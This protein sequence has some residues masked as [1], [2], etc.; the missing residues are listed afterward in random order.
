MEVDPLGDSALLLR[1]PK[2]VTIDKL[3]EMER[4]LAVA[5]LP[6]VIELAP[7]YETLAVFYDPVAVTTDEDASAFEI[8]SRKIVE[9]LN[10]PGSAPSARR[11]KLVEIPVCYG[12]AFGPDLEELAKHARLSAEEV[13][14]RH[15]GARYRVS[16]LGF[17]PG[18]PYLSGLPNE[19]SMPR[20][21][22]P[23]QQVP[24]GAVAIGGN[25]TGV[26]PIASPGGWNLIGR[27]PLALFSASNDPPALL[28][29][30]DE[31]R[32]RP[33]DRAE[34]DSLGQ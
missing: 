11:M 32:F 13:I 8:L 18:F 24:A 1:F 16:C 33:I 20:R 25:Q 9:L 17:T 14:R 28:Q 5:K 7:A 29:A 34:Y 12:G 4:R 15:C 23:R 22:S 6:G 31:V 10:V 2:T 21:A 26:Y 27:T 3:L 19:L 30:G